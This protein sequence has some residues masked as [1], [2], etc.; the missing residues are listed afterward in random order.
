M[1][2]GLLIVAAACIA[3]QVASATSQIPD[4]L[5]FRGEK[6]ALFVNPLEPFFS[7]HQ[8][9]RPKSDV[10]STALWR[11]YVASFEFKDS[12]LYVSD[13]EI[14]VWTTDTSGQRTTAW[15]SVV[16][17]VFADSTERFCRC[18]R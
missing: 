6:Q 11:G 9:R 13:I 2:R 4:R 5:L 10:V 15:K 7:T 14:E 12:T 8:E 17:S 1:H 3:V 16:D 18:A